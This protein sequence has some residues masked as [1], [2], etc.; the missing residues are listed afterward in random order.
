MAKKLHFAYMYLK[1]TCSSEY[2]LITCNAG[3]NERT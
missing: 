1:D 2:K 3:E